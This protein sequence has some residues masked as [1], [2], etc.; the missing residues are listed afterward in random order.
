[1]L[2]GF[3]LSARM[4]MVCAVSKWATVA[5]GA[6]LLLILVQTDVVS[7]ITGQAW[8]SLSPQTQAAIQFDETKRAQVNAFALLGY[9]APMLILFG[10][11]R[12]FR[13]LEAGTVFSI[14][15]VKALRFLGLMVL[16][17]ALFRTLFGSLLILLMT[18]DAV[19]GQRTLSIGLNSNQ[20][21][22]ILV[23]VIFLVIGH[24]F[25]QAVH[26]SDENRQ[27]I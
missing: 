16:V 26:I 9:F 11:F 27:I 12:M 13:A 2:P 6:L 4:R 15:T 25:T 17:E 23:G 19:D 18:Y 21:L 10:A 1:M 20:L 7:E 5:I 22:S 8:N 24:V 3:E 14:R